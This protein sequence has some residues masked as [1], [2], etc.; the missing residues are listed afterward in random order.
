M[1]QE[2]IIVS[3]VVGIA[4]GSGS[5]KT[6]VARRVTER[7]GPERVL[8]LQHDAYYHDLDRMPVHDPAL[9]NYD[10]PDALET[11][12]CA[13]HVRMLKR[14]MSVRQPVYDFSTHRRSRESLLLDPRP[15]ILLDGILVLASEEL[16]NECDVKVY[17]DAGADLRLLRRTE[18]DV[19]ERGRTV[20]SVRD[21]YLRTVRP[22]HDAFVEPS[23]SH[24]DI[25]IPWERE[26]TGAINL[27]VEFLSRRLESR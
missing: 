12:L 13:E 16:R 27:L 18:R 14:G 26:N 5:G 24:A 21:Q 1:N 22:M 4:G 6:T 11:S 3:C 25:V 23:K 2:R 17:V 10:H 7:I 20:A 8:V 15:I 19:M 9:I